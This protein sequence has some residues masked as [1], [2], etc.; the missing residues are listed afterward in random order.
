VPRQLNGWHRLLLRLF[1]ADVGRGV[2]LYPSARIHFPWM[3][4][5]GDFAVVGDNVNVYNL[6]RVRV[7]KHTVVSQNVHI[8][9]GTHDH[10][11]VRMPL[12]RT[13]VVVGQGC[14]IC[15]DAF[16]GPGCSVGDGA[17]VGARSVVTGQLPAQMVCAGNP[18]RPL[19]PRWPEACGDR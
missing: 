3:L 5:L 15:A 9:A 19:K 1:G 16:L 13:P 8:C 10:Q 7:G 11:D 18:C 12:Q 4:E 17:V 6:G 2:T 14:W